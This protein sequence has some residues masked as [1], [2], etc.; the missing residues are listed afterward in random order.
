M[1]NSIL[2]SGI[3]GIVIGIVVT[4]LSLTY[5][6]SR[7]GNMMYSNN[8]PTMI[9]EQPQGMN[10]SMN[11]MTS[12]LESKSG[13]EF[14]KA[15]ISLMIDHH[16]GAIEMANFAKTLAKHNELKKLADDIIV[17]QT[18]EIDQMKTWQQQWGYENS[19]Q[20]NEEELKDLF[21]A[22]K[23]KQ[24]IEPHSGG[25]S[26]TL[27]DG[28]TQRLAGVDNKSVYQMVQNN[29]KH[30]GFDITIAIE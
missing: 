19:N 5:S 17:A 29:K 24:T 12:S 1:K 4:Y 27:T 13:D 6:S 8:P 7:Q 26:I 28:T 16:Q 30:C 11:D 22:C 18:K 21:Q 3:I 15:F 23:V 2:V 10:M 14:D 20:V 9:K 25:M